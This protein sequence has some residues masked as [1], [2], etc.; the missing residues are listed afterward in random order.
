M[1]EA[2]KE[3]IRESSL[4]VIGSSAGGIEAIS[5]LVST[6][7]T[8]FPAPIVLAQHLDPT[9]ASN[10]DMIIRQRSTLPVELVTERSRL[11]PGKVYVVPSNRQVSIEDGHVEVQNDVHTRA[12]PR[13]SVDLLFASAA[14][15]YG[16]RLIA[17]I[18][19]GSG[20]DGAAG[21]VEVKNAGGTVLVQNPQTARY[22]SMPLALPPTVVDFEADIDRIGPLLG[23]LLHGTVAP[24]PEEKT[25]DVLRFIL[26]H[27]SQQ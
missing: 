11:E 26:E 1:S 4:V 15:V 14:K 8:D 2:V 6:L 19:T 24:S 22:P 20:S 21:A 23:E 16:E 5:V 25:E 13:P 3:E 9:R 27:V 12:R 17:V 18:L 7:P 10:L